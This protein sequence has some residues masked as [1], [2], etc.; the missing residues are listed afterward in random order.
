MIDQAAPVDKES[1]CVPR[2]RGSPISTSPH[3]ADGAGAL[4]GTG[5]QWPVRFG[6]G[7]EGCGPSQPPVADINTA[8][9]RRSGRPP[10]N[11]PAIGPSDSAEAWSAAVPR[12]R[13]FADINT[14]FTAPT[15]RTPSREPASNWPVRF[16]GG[17]EGCGPSQPPVADI[18]T[19]SRR[20]RSERPPGNR[21]AMARPIRW[22][23]GGLRSLA[24]GGSPTSTPVSRRRRSGR[25]PGNRPAMARP[26]GADLEG[27][28]PSQRRFADINTVSRRRWSGR[29]PG[30]R[31]AM[32][33]LFSHLA[34]NVRPA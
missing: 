24:A 23:P 12:S 17:V 14:R 15:E 21:P 7:L 1:H 20:R 31:P 33:D 25:P 22:R 4:Q 16:G 26:I 19:A 8:S 9:R 13:R 5:Q 32:K 2:S 3:G 18:N 27:C 30:N 6:G 11:R 34:I 28:G 10:G 29:P